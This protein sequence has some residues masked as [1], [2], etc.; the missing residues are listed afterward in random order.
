MAFVASVVCYELGHTLVA[1]I[2]IAVTAVLSIFD[3]SQDVGEAMSFKFGVPLID[4]C[5]KAEQAP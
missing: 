4:N 1:L 3:I 2:C 5:T